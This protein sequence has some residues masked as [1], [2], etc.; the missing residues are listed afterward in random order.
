MRDP[1]ET[2][3][4]RQEAAWFANDCQGDIEDYGSDEDFDK[5]E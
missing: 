5:E 4:E 2:Y 3:F 1:N